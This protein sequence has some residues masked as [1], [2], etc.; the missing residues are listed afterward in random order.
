MFALLRFAEDTGETSNPI[1]PAV[2]EIFWGAIAF[3]TLFPAAP[4]P[5][6]A[7]TIAPSIIAVLSKLCR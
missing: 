6:A 3:F 2:N 7:A 4:A 1:L 5:A